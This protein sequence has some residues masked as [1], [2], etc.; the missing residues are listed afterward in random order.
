MPAVLI[1]ARPLRVPGDHLPDRRHCRR[2]R[3][4]RDGHPGR[5][6]MTFAR[7]RMAVDELSSDLELAQRL[8]SA[9][10]VHIARHAS[11]SRRRHRSGLEPAA[12]R[13]RAPTSILEP[14]EDA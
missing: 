2:D 7:C 1:E 13:S 14:E 11:P 10:H 3:G 12:R 9:A 6:P 4:R 5:H 8:G